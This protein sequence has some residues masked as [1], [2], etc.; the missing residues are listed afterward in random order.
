MVVVSTV[1]VLVVPD[2]TGE[3]LPVA[4][5]ATLVVSVVDVSAVALSRVMV[6]AV[7]VLVGA[8][9]TGTGAIP[10]SLMTYSSAATVTRGGAGTIHTSPTVTAITRTGPTD[11]ADTLTMDTAG[12]VTTA[13]A[14]TDIALA[15]DQGMSAVRGGGDKP[16]RR[17]GIARLAAR[18]DRL[19]LSTNLVELG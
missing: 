8:I 10:D 6:F 5:S 15:T 3:A 14:V 11:T 18:V 13:P 4:V 12:T 1:A 17:F 2:S 19:G 16:G 7:A 9:G